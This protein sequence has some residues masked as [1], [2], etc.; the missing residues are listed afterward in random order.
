MGKN[1]LFHVVPNSVRFVQD[2]ILGNQFLKS[3]AAMIDFKNNCLC[4]DDFIIPFTDTVNIKI[5]GRTVFPFYVTITN[6]QKQ[7]DFISQTTLATGLYY[8][9][10]IVTNI[11][12]KAYLPVT[13]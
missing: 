9:E 11:H 5:P 2:E 1:T 8:G 13:S 3:H 4:Y 7:Y 10:A 6:S 12:G